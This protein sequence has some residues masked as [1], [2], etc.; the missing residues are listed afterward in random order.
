MSCIWSTVTG[1]EAGVT[2][3]HSLALVC[4]GKLAILTIRHL[5]S[6]LKATYRPRVRSQ[7]SR[8]WMHGERAKRDLVQVSLS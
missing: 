3:L 2:N 4:F 5:S 8:T 7:L 1:N 6:V